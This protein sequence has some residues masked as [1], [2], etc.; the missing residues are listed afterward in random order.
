[1]RAYTPLRAGWLSTPYHDAMA[2]TD[3]TLTYTGPAV[4]S[5]SMNVVDLAPALLALSAAVK[6]ARLLVDPGS[7]TVNLEI[8]AT[9]VGSF[10]VHMTV[11]ESLIDQARNMFSGDSATALANLCAYLFGPLTGVVAL[12]K[13]LYRR[14][15]R[16]TREIDGG[17]LELE[18]DDGQQRQWPVVVVNLYMSEPVRTGMRDTIAPL[19][20]EGITGVTFRTEGDPETE[21]V[22]EAEVDAFEVPLVEEELVNEYEREVVLSIRS[23]AFTSGNKWRFD[24]GDAPFFAAIT[25][26]SFL[27]DV[28]KESVSFRA[29]DQLRCRLVTKQ[30]RTDE[31]LRSEHFVTKVLDLIPAARQIQ[32]PGME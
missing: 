13:W 25:D 14:K 29:H 26:V 32:L 17:M 23:L 9:D 4:D 16:S 6:E 15:I 31:G 2:A 19:H 27:S 18:L 8:R 5:G 20:R 30:Y 3:L 7:P 12:T 22:S 24:A 10:A 1:M 21:S 28:D 11:V